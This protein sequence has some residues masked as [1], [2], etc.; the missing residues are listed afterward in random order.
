MAREDVVAGLNGF[1]NNLICPWEHYE[2]SAQVACLMGLENEF[3]ADSKV[4][5]YIS[6]SPEE[7]LLLFIGE[8][9]DASIRKDGSA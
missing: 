8:F 1:F 9:D 2:S 7:V 4:L 5:V 6:K 3:D